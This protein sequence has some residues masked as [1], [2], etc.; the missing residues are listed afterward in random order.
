MPFHFCDPHQRIN[1]HR[2]QA[3]GLDAHEIYTMRQNC[4]TMAN[5]IDAVISTQTTDR[6]LQPSP[7]TI[8]EQAHTGKCGRPTTEIDPTALQQ[9]LELRG[10]QDTARLL[11]C[12]S[13][14]VRRRA[15]EL[16]FVQPGAPVFTHETQPDGSVLKVF[17]RRDSAHS[18]DEEVHAAVPVV[19]ETYPDIGREKMVAALK[20]QGISATRRQVEAALLVSRGP[21][22]S[23]K[24][25]PIQRRVY[26]V[27]GSNYMWHH[28][29][30]TVCHSYAIVFL[31]GP[32]MHL[33]LIR[34]K[35]VIH[36]FAD[37]HVRFVVGIQVNPNNR[38][39]TVFNLFQHATATHG[40]PHHVRGDH[41][42]ENVLVADY[43]ESARGPGSYI[44][45]R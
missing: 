8:S 42:V 34:W 11:G 5:A 25:G 31:F 41:G 7:V 22:D 38:A 30:S 1:L 20:A 9:L 14:T 45:G 21:S 19:L 18:T 29:A 24:R 27:P 4:A 40:T 26:N 33:G 15:L 39:V 12:S 32:H 13:R 10:P 16:G 36:A 28:V 35:L 23:R 6:D 37:G 17:R 44:W 2:G 3:Q 43:M